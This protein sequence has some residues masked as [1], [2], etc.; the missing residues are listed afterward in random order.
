[1]ANMHVDR[2]E[3][4]DIEHGTQ[5][6]PQTLQQHLSRNPAAISEVKAHIV[7]CSLAF[8][9]SKSPHYKVTCLETITGSDY[10]VQIY[11]SGTRSWRLLGSS[12]KIQDHMIHICYEKGVYFNGA[13]HWVDRYCEMSCFDIDEERV[14]FVQSPS[15]CREKNLENRKYRYFKET[16]G[17]HLHLIDIYWPYFGFEVL[18]MG[19]DYSGWFVKYNVDLLPLWNASPHS[20]Y[21]FY[22]HFVVPF[23][24]RDENEEWDSSSLWLHFPGQVCSYNLKSHTFNFFDLTTDDV[25]LLN[26]TI[27]HENEEDGSLS[28]LLHP[29]GNVISCNLKSKTFKSFELTTDE[30]LLVEHLNFMYKESLACV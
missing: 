20:H 26:L 18:E 16:S 13:V 12:F 2:L 4:R 29:P 14:E 3:L 21:F 22:G 17:G 5:A 23:L 28:L 25:S 24:D 15:H 8:D 9:P 27:F 6:L 11:S 10:Q 7:G 30:R 19:R 1:M